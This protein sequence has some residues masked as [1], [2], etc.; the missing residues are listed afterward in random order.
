MLVYVCH[1]YSKDPVGNTGKVKAICAD[2]IA[3]DMTPVAPQL[4][5]PQLFDETTQRPQVMAACIDLME[6]C[7]HIFIYGDELT[8]GMKQE[9][10]VAY[11]KGKM[12]ENHSSLPIA[13]VPAPDNGPFVVSLAE[14][15]SDVPVAG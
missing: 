13:V 8:D 1:A 6:H 15:V 14:G 11:Q 10:G 5:F 7:D 4:Y 9:L 12:V 3:N 2:L